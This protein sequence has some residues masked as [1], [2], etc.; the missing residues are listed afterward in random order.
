MLCVAITVT[1]P[2]ATCA[3]TAASA[4]GRLLAPVAKGAPQPEAA[5]AVAS[6]VRAFL[7]AVAE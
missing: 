1:S 2:I 5:A 6:A 3:A 4:T 7:S